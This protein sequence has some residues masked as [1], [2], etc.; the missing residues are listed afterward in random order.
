MAKRIPRDN[1]CSGSDISNI[2]DHGNEVEVSGRPNRMPL[3]ILITSVAAVFVFLAVLVYFSVSS[4]SL[5][6]INPWLITVIVVVVFCA[7][8]FEI[9][10]KPNLFLYRDLVRDDRL[11]SEEHHGENQS[12]PQQEHVSQQEKDRG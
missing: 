8:A 7:I 5:P 12:H 4:A 9:L 2:L 1:S 11:A 10:M 3:I 6:S